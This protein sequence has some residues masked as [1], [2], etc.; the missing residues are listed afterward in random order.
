MRHTKI[1]YYK[2]AM[3]MLRRLLRFLGFERGGGASK[4][5]LTNTCF[6][7][8]DEFGNKENEGR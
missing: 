6:Q 5:L 8:V 1:F 4:C 3:L 7:R 2:S